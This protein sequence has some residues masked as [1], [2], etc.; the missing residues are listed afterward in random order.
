M[1]ELGKERELQESRKM[2]TKEKVKIQIDSRVTSDGTVGGLIKM[3]STFDPMLE[4]K[5]DD[6]ALGI[7]IVKNASIEFEYGNPK[8]FYVVIG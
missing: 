6:D 1:E 8:K 2:T 4:V 7:R 5:C 3:L